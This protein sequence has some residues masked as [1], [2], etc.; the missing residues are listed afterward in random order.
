VSLTPSVTQRAIRPSSTY[1][2]IRSQNLLE[3]TEV[4]AACSQK[5]GCANDASTVSTNGT[6]VPFVRFEACKLRKHRIMLFF[7]GL[8][9]MYVL[10][11]SIAKDLREMYSVSPCSS[12]SYKTIYVP[13]TVDGVRHNFYPQQKSYCASR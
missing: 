7:A 3:A 6:D 13:R 9:L 5:Q 10:W 2:S 4:C 11:F 12:W 1:V 8:P